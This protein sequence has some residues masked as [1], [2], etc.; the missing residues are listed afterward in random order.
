MTQRNI[1][2]TESELEILE[3]LW[4]KGPSSVRTVNDE[5]NQ[6]RPVGYTTTLKT[7]Q[8]MTEKEL[9]ERDTTER[10]HIY[11]ATVKE[12]DTKISMLKDFI[13]MAFSGSSAQLVLQALGSQKPS[14][15]DLEEIKSL[16]D[17]LEKEK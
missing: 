17:Q 9:V 5:L 1:K 4:S 14:K 6:S 7:M 3:V 8:I 15:E 10:T 13:N 12:S 11:S 16:I 2:P